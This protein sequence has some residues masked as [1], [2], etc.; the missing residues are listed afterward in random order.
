[1]AVI[2]TNLAVLIIAPPLFLLPVRTNLVASIACIWLTITVWLKLV[3]YHMVNW[4][5]R[6][7]DP[8]EQK[9]GN[10]NVSLVEKD[11]TACQKTNGAAANGHVAQFVVYPDNLYAADI[12]YFM[13]APTL[14]YE[15]NFPQRPKIRKWFLLWIT[16]EVVWNTVFWIM[17][18]FWLFHSTL[19][20]LGE[21]LRFADRDFYRDWWN[22]NSV[23][24]FWNRWNLP[25]HRWCW[26]HI[27]NPLV[28]VGF[29]KTQA[30]M[31]VFGV[32]AVFHEYIM[33]LPLKKVYGVAF[34]G[35]AIQ[36]PLFYL[37]DNVIPE[38]FPKIGNGIIVVLFIFVMPLVVTLYYC[39]YFSIIIGEQ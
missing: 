20:W 13:F 28:S 35:M 39:K 30:Q 1:M 31:A 2:V 4:S 27:Y 21:V 9:T 23:R 16:L 7:A 10:G 6:G 12:W 34:A 5:S 24:G 29:T 22:A 19:N 32:S 25:V 37:Y 8:S 33:S 11:G 17:M 38:R 36:L 3:S 14:C 15:I 26:R 18:S